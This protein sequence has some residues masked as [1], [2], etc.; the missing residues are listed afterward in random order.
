MNFECEFCKKTFSTKSNLSLHKKTTKKCLK[1]Q[2]EIGNK[3]ENIIF[4]CNFCNKYFSL[5]HNLEAHTITCKNKKET[6]NKEILEQLK[7]LKE[8]LL[9]HEEQRKKEKQEYELLKLKNTELENQVEKL[10]NELEK[11]KK[12]TAKTVYNI[13]VD[14]IINNLPAL[15]NENIKGSFLEHV[16]IDSVIRGTDRF[17]I[18]F[19][20]IAKEYSM[21]ADMSRGK[22]IAKDEKGE[23]LDFQF[24]SFVQQLFKM[25]EEEG[26]QLTEEALQEIKNKDTDEIFDTLNIKRNKEIYDIQHAFKECAQD[27]DHDILGEVV[28]RL[29][30]QGKLI[31]K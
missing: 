11:E 28:S 25:C 5:K 22:L 21:I 31:S 17:V 19:T 27:R 1:I 15:T 10:K 9:I 30:K 6:N 12:R 2:A 3:E 29:R 23:K 13:K 16:N 26:L 8:E 14:K 7:S 20:K 18:D 24:E 4:S